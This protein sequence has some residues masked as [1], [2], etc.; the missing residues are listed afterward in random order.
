MKNEGGKKAGLWGG[1]PCFVGGCWLFCAVFNRQWVGVEA[2]EISGSWRFV[3]SC[4]HSSARKG[5]SSKKVHSSTKPRR[6]QGKKKRFVVEI[7]TIKTIVIEDFQR[8]SYAYYLQYY[9]YKVE[10]ILL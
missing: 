8:Y 2:W 3:G 1:R 4:I 7:S 5:R 10:S 6:G 9:R